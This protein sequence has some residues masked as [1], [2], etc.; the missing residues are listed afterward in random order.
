[1]VTSLLVYYPQYMHAHIHPHI[2]MCPPIATPYYRTAL[3]LI[4]RNRVSM[5]HA[6]LEGK[7]LIHTLSPT[8]PIPTLQKVMGCFNPLCLSQLHDT[9]STLVI[10][11]V[12]TPPLHITAIT[13]II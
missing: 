6:L 1:M 13:Y 4:E 5:K 10:K 8:R 7:G 3:Q 9:R 11:N 12:K 2:S